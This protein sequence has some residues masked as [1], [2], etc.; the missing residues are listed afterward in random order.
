[1]NAVVIAIAVMFLLS[2]ARVSVVLTL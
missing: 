1:M 2:L